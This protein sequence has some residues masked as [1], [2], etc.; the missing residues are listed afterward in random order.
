M[1]YLDRVLERLPRRAPTSYHFECWR[2]GSK[3]TS[4]GLGLLPVRDI[5]SEQLVAAVMDVDH[6]VG[7]IGHVLEARTIPDGLHRPPKVLHCYELV[8]IP[9]VA[10][11]QNEFL[12]EDRGEREGYRVMSWRQIDDATARL[13]PKKGARGDF[14]EGAWLVKPGLLG[15]A[16]SSAPRREDVG[17]LKFTAL[18]KGADA[19]APGIFKANLE[20]MV[21]WVGRRAGR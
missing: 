13:D 10:R 14:T 2:H 6:Y 5:D 16:L 19:L 11:I 21:K 8:D 4:E 20:C 12:L 17:L 15:Y 1:E 18:T 9:V 7:N 3:P